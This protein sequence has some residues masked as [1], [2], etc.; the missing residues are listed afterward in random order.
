M[1]SPTAQTPVLT[2]AAQL[3]DLDEAAV[4]DRDTRCRRGRG[5]R[6]SGV[7]PTDIDDDVDVER[8]AADLDGGAGSSGRVA[9]DR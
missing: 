9:L 5:R 8:L 1:A 2:G 4:A 6:C 3:V 7:R